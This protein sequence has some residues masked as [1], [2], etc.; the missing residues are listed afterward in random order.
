MSNPI[1]M[2]Q[3][4]NLDYCDPKIFLSDI[5]QF[6][7]SSL[8]LANTPKR[9]RTLRTNKLKGD[10]EMRDAALF[11]LGMSEIIDCKVYFSATED[12]DYDFIARYILKD[13]IH[14]APVQL[15]ELVDNQTY[16]LAS[17]DKILDGLKKYS[18]LEN[19]AI[20][21]KLGGG[22]RFDPSSVTMPPD[23]KIGSF[24]VFGTI[25]ELQDKWVIWG[26]FASHTSPTGIMYEYPELYRT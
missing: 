24:W 22:F 17:I 9:I 25:D 2:R 8:E 10:R 20:A 12:Q 7:R 26:D 19:L 15:K 14:Y 3:W 21:V 6:E 5:R 13:T 16:K 4:R 18:D 11:C 23:L 1:L